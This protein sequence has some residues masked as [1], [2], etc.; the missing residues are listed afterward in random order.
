MNNFVSLKGLVGNDPTVYDGNKNAFAIISIAQNY[1]VNEQ[2][3]TSWFD[4]TVFGDLIEKSKYLKKGDL[5]HVS[6]QISPIKKEI[7]GKKYVFNKLIA[8][9]L[10]KIQKLS[11]A[12]SFDDIP[13]FEANEEVPF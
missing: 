6:G 5:I 10:T 13:S 3:R 12:S 9:S 8:R 7:N 2:E 1:K 4:I 11:S